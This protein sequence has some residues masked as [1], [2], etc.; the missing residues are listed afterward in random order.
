MITLECSQTKGHNKMYWYR[1]DLGMEL[2]LIHYSY[3]VNSS[4]KGELPFEST[5]SRVRKEHFSLRLVSTSPSHTSQYLCASSHT[6]LHG[7]LQPAHKGQ[8][9]R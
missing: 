3:G 5:A 6:A 9:Q 2:Q 7:H 4:E 1:Q 8:S